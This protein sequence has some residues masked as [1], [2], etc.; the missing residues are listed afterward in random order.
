MGNNSNGFAKHS[1]W[2]V[3]VQISILDIRTVHTGA[4]CSGAVYKTCAFKIQGVL[5]CVL[6]LPAPSA[7]ALCDNPVCQ[8]LDKQ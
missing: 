8:E 6:P 3:S 7:E 1:I 2:C 5:P 4:L